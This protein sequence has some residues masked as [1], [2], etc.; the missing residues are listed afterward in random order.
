[1][2]PATKTFEAFDIQL[3]EYTQFTKQ[4]AEIIQNVAI[5][6]APHLQSIVDTVHGRI[7]DQFPGKTDVY[8]GKEPLRRYLGRI[9]TGPY[10]AS[11]L[12][13]VANDSKDIDP[14][15]TNAVL[16]ALHST[17]I[18]QITD[19]RLVTEIAT[20]DAFTKLLWLQNH[21]FLQHYYLTMTQQTRS[22]LGNFVYGVPA[23]LGRCPAFPVLLGATLGGLTVW[24]GLRKKL[25][26]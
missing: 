12:R 3:S 23:S 9:M 17:L 5:K 20:L 24:I 26:A 2:Q 19:L 25:L 13:W 14:I 15:Y 1:M 22:T 21:C 11:Y 4:D 6:L 10:D 18:R 7:S 16:G 8:L